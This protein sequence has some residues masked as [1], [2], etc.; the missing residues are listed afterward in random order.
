MAPDAR[1]GIVSVFEGCVH[2]AN[3]PAMGESAGEGRLRGQK[4]LDN[5]SPCEYFWSFVRI[6]RDERE[7][8][9]RK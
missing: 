1:E 3:I 4:D 9:C 6:G 5:R 2:S 7:D 8:L